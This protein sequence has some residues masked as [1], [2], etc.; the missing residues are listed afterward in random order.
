MKFLAI[1]LIKLYKFTL[2][3][4]FGNE[5]RFYPTC[6]DYGIICFQNFSFF[7]AFYLSLYRILRCNPYCKGGFDHPL[8]HKL[9]E[10]FNFSGDYNKSGNINL[11]EESCNHIKKIQ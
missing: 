11:R 2:S 5:C 7:K 10:T 8:E 3:H 1:Q 9:D 6:S 4:L